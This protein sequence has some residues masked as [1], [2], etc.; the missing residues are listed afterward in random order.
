MAISGNFVHEICQV[1]RIIF[2]IILVYEWHWISFLTKCQKFTPRNP[3]LGWRSIWFVPVM[4][5]ITGICITPSLSGGA[6]SNSPTYISAHS[7]MRLIKCKVKH[8]SKGITKIRAHIQSSSQVL[9]CSNS[10]MPWPQVLYQVLR[11]TSYCF[12]SMIPGRYPT[13]IMR[14]TIIIII[15]GLYKNRMLAGAEH[16]ILEKLG[17]I[18]PF[19]RHSLNTPEKSEEVITVLSM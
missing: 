7:A 12:F 1:W 8:K 3:W 16:S 9:C 6:C 17:N 4:P 10:V 18:L 19:A 2:M 13:G 14:K 5:R 11:A 15:I